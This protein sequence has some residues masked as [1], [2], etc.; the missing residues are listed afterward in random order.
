MTPGAGRAGQLE[1]QR[2]TRPA[3]ERDRALDRAFDAEWV[4]GVWASNVAGSMLVPVTR[5]TVVTRPRQAPVVKKF[6]GMD[7]SS[8]VPA[9]AVLCA[10]HECRRQL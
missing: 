10:D 6:G 9:G 5:A 8:G 3:R 7:P 2:R 1:P 4:P